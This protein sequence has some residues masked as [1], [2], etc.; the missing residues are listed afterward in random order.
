MFYFGF[1]LF[2]IL[3]ILINVCRVH[4]L[5]GE[6]YA[7]G[8]KRLKVLSIGFVCIFGIGM[9]SYMHH[10]NTV[11]QYDE[12]FNACFDESLF[13]AKTNGRNGIRLNVLSIKKEYIVYPDR[14]SHSAFVEASQRWY[15]ISKHAQ[16]DTLYIGKGEH[17]FYVLL[18]APKEHWYD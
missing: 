3:V 8:I 10:K 1:V 18:D 4:D 14:I 6:E 17:N 11:I 7:V 15:K 2:G 13:I 5:S 12:I 9:Y 16:S